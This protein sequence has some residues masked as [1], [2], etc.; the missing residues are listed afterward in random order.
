[1]VTALSGG[2]WRRLVQ[3]TTASAPG[4]VEK[5]RLEFTEEMKS[6]F[7]FGEADHQ[8]GFDL[9]RATR[10]AVMFRLTIGT[11]DTDRRRPHRRSTHLASANSY[12][13]N[14]APGGRLRV[15]RA[16]FNLFV[17]GGEVNAEAARHMLYRLWFADGVGRPLTLVGFNGIHQPVAAGRRSGT[18]APRP[19][20]LYTRLLAGH[21]EAGGDADAPR[22]EPG[23]STSCPSTA[24]ASWRRCGSEAPPRTPVAGLRGLRRDVG[25]ALGGFSSP[26]CRGAPATEES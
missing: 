13:A 17:D 4:S 24:P 25:P 20:T 6:Y 9:G 3:E 7:T 10:T 21:V 16:V 14:D 15:E 26:D 5:F 19:R 8:R 22:S 1:M 11:D 23:A 12:V 2:V 18:P